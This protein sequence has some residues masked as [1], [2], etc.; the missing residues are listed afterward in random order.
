MVDVAVC[1]YDG[2]LNS[3]AD[4]C[5]KFDIDRFDGT[6]VYATY[7]YE[8]YSGHGYVL[9]IEDGQFWQTCGSH[10]SCNGLEGQWSPELVTVDV[11]QHIAD[12]GYGDD[13]EAARRALR[14]MDDLGHRDPDALAALIQLRF[15]SN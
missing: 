15:G 8:S 2:D 3:R 13:Q 7:S 6:V 12:N 4:V 1:R 11:I 9:Y 10:C 14:V 5:E